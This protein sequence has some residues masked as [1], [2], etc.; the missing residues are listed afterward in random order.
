M[1]EKRNIKIAKQDQADIN[2][3]IARLK[4]EGRTLASLKNPTAEQTARLNAILTTELTAL[5]ERQEAIAEELVRFERLR[6]EEIA[7][8]THGAAAREGLIAR[9]TGRRFAEMFPN[10]ALHDGGFGGRG[11]SAAEEF[12]ATIHSG[13]ADQRLMAVN[14]GTSG[15]DGGFA[16]P[17]Q[18]FAQ[19]LDASLESEIVR[20]RCDVRPMTSREG[21]AP[22]WDDGDH[23]S[24]LYG[25]FTGQWIEEG[26]DIDVETPKMRLIAMKARKL[27]ILARVSNELIADGMSFEQQLGAAITK[28]L[29]WFLD[30]AFLSGVGA[31][32]PLGSIDATGTVTVT[33]EIG[34]AAGTIVY[35]N[36]AKMFARLA[37]GSHEQAVWVCNSTAIPYLLQLS[38]PIGTSGS[39]VPVLSESGGKW[40]MLTRPVVFTEKV[41]TLGTKGDI[42]LYDFSQY[43][44]GLRADFT[45]AKSMH[46]GFQ[47]DTT[48]YRGTIRVDGQPKRATVIT[49]NAGDTLSPFVVLETRS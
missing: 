6:E 13:L 2:A 34:Q 48:Y 17:P 7:Q 25:G 30:K 44:V 9:G 8:S 1:H 23:S 49:P 35:A 21:V 40:T 46:A 11:R 12:L 10:V 22:G 27:A 45:L 32:G 15:A 29:G 26:G 31:P 38:I 28:A 24:T 3:A 20:S 4:R 18:I 16:V 33:K 47:S 43:V 19:W 39:H 41:P 37:P 14:T 42:G 5:E 36:L